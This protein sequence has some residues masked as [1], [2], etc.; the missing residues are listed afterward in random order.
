MAYA[1]IPF[2]VMPRPADAPQPKP[3]MLKQRK[4]DLN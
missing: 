3:V 1:N 2:Y 4:L